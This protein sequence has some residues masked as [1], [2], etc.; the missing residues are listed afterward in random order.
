MSLVSL[1]ETDIPS[2]VDVGYRMELSIGTSHLVIKDHIN[3]FGKKT[4]AA[5]G[6]ALICRPRS[7]Q[8]VKYVG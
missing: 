1:T 2:Q 7:G 5:A 3:E 8:G 4:T 6:G